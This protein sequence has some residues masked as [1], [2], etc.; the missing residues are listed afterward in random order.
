MVNFYWFIENQS[1]NPIIDGFHPHEIVETFARNAHKTG[2]NSNKTGRLDRFYVYQSLVPI[3]E[4]CRIK[5]NDSSDHLS[6]L[7]DLV[8]PGHGDLIPTC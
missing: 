2:S 8:K 7:F 5:F 3:I 6:C 4:S 1:L